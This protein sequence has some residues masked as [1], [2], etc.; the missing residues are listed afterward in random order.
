MIFQLNK[1]NFIKN[2]FITLLFCTFLWISS[3]KIY[4]I[5]SFP[6][7]EKGGHAWGLQGDKGR[8]TDVYPYRNSLDGIKRICEILEQ[9]HVIFAIMAPNNNKTLNCDSNS[10]YD[11]NALQNYP[12]FFS[13]NI[14]CMI[15]SFLISCQ[16][17]FGYIYPRYKIC[18]ITL[19]IISKI[20]LINSII[21]YGYLIY[22]Y[23][24]TFYSIDLYLII[25]LTI[26]YSIDQKNLFIN[27]K[28][29]LLLENQ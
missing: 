18:Y 7:L 15:T 21:L 14:L 27:K 25:L 26:F 12:V 4:K 23:G 19:L 8:V 10:I 3:Y 17:I 20:L 9:K 11:Y 2:S 24:E 16:I 5:V 1:K 22:N 29:E 6:G 13:Q 28:R